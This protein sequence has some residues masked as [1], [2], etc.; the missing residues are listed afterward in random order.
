MNAS[1]SGL[2][3]CIFR[4]IADMYSLLHICTLSHTCRFTFR[5]VLALGYILTGNAGQTATGVIILFPL[6]SQVMPMLP[7]GCLWSTLTVSPF[8][9]WEESQSQ[10]A[11]ANQC[12][13]ESRKLMN[14]IQI[15]DDH[16]SIQL[17]VN[18]ICLLVG[19]ATDIW[20][21]FHILP[22]L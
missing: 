12:S 8:S 10:A 3:I 9:P 21:C 5:L 11:S 2:I 19:S 7:L 20:N 6:R 17:Q 18:G 14:C 13:S 4:R 1:T 16:C 15:M 22:K